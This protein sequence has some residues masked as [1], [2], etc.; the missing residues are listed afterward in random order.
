MTTPL[1]ERLFSRQPELHW[2]LD[3]HGQLL[4][5]LLHQ[6]G[7][8]LL[9]KHH[10][11]S[12][13]SDVKDVFLWAI[14]KNASAP[15]LQ[16]TFDWLHKTMVIVHSY[17]K[18]TDNFLH[19]LK[20]THPEL[21]QHLM[22]TIT[23]RNS[24]WDTS[25]ALKYAP[26]PEKLWEVKRSWHDFYNAT[27]STSPLTWSRKETNHANACPWAKPDEAV[28]QRLHDVMGAQAF[29]RWQYG[30]YLAVLSQN[31]STQDG[32]PSGRKYGLASALVLLE[33]SIKLEL[34]PDP[35]VLAQD[36]VRRYK[37]QGLVEDMLKGLDYCMEKYEGN[38]FVQGLDYCSKMLNTIVPFAISEGM[39]NGNNALGMDKKITQ[40][41]NNGRMAERLALS[42]FEARCQKGRTRPVAFKTFAPLWPET[43]REKLVVLESKQLRKP[44]TSDANAIVSLLETW[45]FEP[46]CTSA[47]LNTLTP[48]QWSDIQ[49]VLDSNE[50]TSA[51]V[52]LLKTSHPWIENYKSSTRAR[53]AVVAA[54]MVFIN[55]PQYVM[56]PKYRELGGLFGTSNNT[57]IGELSLP[58]P[59]S[60]FANCFPQYRETWQ[61]LACDMADQRPMGG[62]RSMADPN[63]DTETN[64]AH[65]VVN[66]LASLM[67]GKSVDA[68][69]LLQIRE[70]LD[71]NMSYETLVQ[72]QLNATEVFELPATFDENMFASDS[73]VV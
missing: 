9:V 34:A 33:P 49:Q 73:P 6:W 31:N 70:S 12:P 23:W 10:Y 62:K 72:S 69:S 28:M 15:A 40:A 60:Y 8:Q 16:S 65:K 37:G 56:N 11:T 22:E 57:P 19:S 61:R 24:V 47:I 52:S 48:E 43:L 66:A 36:T 7:Q 67:L 32:V 68:A 45:W 53:I 4:E 14:E 63:R 26:D 3:T 38:D 42:W 64:A 35:Q 44:N 21:L 1:Q 20:S 71:P 55:E 27:S 59:L 30:A 39:A 2:L 46:T 50:R 13:F 41:V 51:V 25:F 18:D 17:P 58:Q 29:L 5:P 54:C